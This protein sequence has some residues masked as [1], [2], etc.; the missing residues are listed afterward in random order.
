MITIPENLTDFL[1]WVKERTEAFWS[2]DPETSTEDF[3]CENWLYGAKWVGLSDDEIDTVEEKHGIKF[4]PEHREFLKILH[5]VDRKEPIEY[6]E[7]FEEDAEELIRYIPYF[8][9]WLQDEELI[10]EQFNWPLTSIMQDVMGANKVWLKSWGEYTDDEQK[11]TTIVT[12]W[13][14]K[15]P[16]LLP[17]T[18]HR[19]LVSDTSLDYRPVLSV[20]GSDVVVYGWNLRSYLLNELREELNVQQLVYNEEDNMEYIELLPEVQEIFNYDYTH[21]EGREIPYWQEM[22]LFWSSGWDS[23]G[24]KVPGETGA[25]AYPIVKMYT[26]EG[27]PDDQKTFES[28]DNS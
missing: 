10:R 8:Y 5:T 23:F 21:K 2:I 17:L 14:D 6:T 28:H 15:A 7:P 26:V 19:F 9:N 16:K 18:S 1:Y 11:A 27:L 24:I 22:I 25:S 13:L 12:G 3:V 20:W 4:T